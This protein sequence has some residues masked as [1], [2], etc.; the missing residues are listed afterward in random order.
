MWLINHSTRLSRICSEFLHENDGNPQS[1]TRERD[2][3]LGGGAPIRQHVSQAAGRVNV[4]LDPNHNDP[5]LSRYPPSTAM[6]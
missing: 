6:I 1:R 4:S 2:A 5:C 3:A